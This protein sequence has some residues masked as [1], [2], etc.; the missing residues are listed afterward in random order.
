MSLAAA[1]LPQHSGWRDGRHQRCDCP[2]PVAS[3]HRREQR[4]VRIL[5]VSANL[6]ATSRI[7]SLG[8]GGRLQS[9]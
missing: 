3:R 9:M 2:P 6:L 7:P 4:A 5:N 1:S 8:H